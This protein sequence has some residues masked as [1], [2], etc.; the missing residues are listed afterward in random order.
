MSMSSHTQNASRLFLE[1]LSRVVPVTLFSIHGG[2]I[3]V[4]TSSSNLIPLITILKNHTGMEFSQLI[5]VA[6]VD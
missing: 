6:S 1:R 4:K 2:E 3:T 5:D